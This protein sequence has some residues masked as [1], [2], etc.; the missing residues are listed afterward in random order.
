MVCCLNRTIHFSG[1]HGLEGCFR[2][3]LACSYQVSSWSLFQ[4][5]S[6]DIVADLKSSIPVFSTF[7]LPPRPTLTIETAAVRKLIGITFDTCWQLLLQC[8]LRFADHSGFQNSSRLFVM[9]H[10]TA[11]VLCRFSMHCSACV[12]QAAQM[13]V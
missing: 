8:R 12:P 3:A 9:R 4:K 10:H 11:Y 1:F 7:N 13:Q 2:G 6:Q 5:G